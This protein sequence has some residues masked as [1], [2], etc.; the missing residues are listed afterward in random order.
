[1]EDNDESLKKKLKNEFIL[2]AFNSTAHGISHMAKSK[3]LFMTTLWTLFFI[4]STYYCFHSII[5]SFIEYKSYG[6]I[7]K[8]TRVQELPATFPAITFCNI[9]PFNERFAYD[10]ILEKTQKA[11]CFEETDVQSFRTCLNTTNN[12][13]AAMDVF[14]DR[15]KRIIANDK[16]LTEDDYYF[17]GY[18][19]KHDMLVSCEYNGEDCLEENFKKY[20]S[21]EYGNC[22]TFNGNLT[23]EILTSSVT[24]CKH[25]L[26]LELVVSKYLLFISNC[27][28]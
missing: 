10:Y 12:K 3:N 16:S 7:M 27:E 11:E 22:Y 18:D 5:Q 2:W 21:N 20:W 25:G 1:M 9:N 26:Q 14:V 19:I 8:I 17:I 13:N 23:D 15:I 4:V 28:V 6:V 24:G